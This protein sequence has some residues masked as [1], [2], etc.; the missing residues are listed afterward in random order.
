M[1][2]CFAFFITPH[3]FCINVS[4]MFP[5]IQCVHVI[6]TIVVPLD[7]A[8]FPQVVQS[9]ESNYLLTISSS[10]SSLPLPLL[11]GHWLAPNRGGCLGGCMGK[12]RLWFGDEGIRGTRFIY[13]LPPRKFPGKKYDLLATIFCLDDSGG[14]GGRN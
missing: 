4:A 2:I 13:L 12:M 6:S 9:E 14:V 8:G 11:R 10:G 7:S 5:N 3:F 1:V